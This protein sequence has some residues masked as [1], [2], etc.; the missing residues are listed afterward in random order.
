MADGYIKLHR[1]ILDS[2]I[3]ASA[4]GLKIWIWC[5][6]KAT[7]KTKHIPVKI[8]KGETIVTIQPGQFIFGR[9]TAEESLCI[10]GSTI[11]KWINKFKDENMIK[12]NSNSHYT[13]VTICK[14]DEY[15]QM[16]DNDVTAIQQPFN[17]HST[18]IQQPRNTNKNIKES[19]E[20]K[21]KEELIYIDEIYSAYP[22]K[23]P[24]RK[25]STS[26]SKKDKEKIKS[27]LSTI[28]KDKL[29]ATINTYVNDCK[30]NNIYLKN[31]KT[32]LNNIPDIDEEILKYDFFSM[33]PNENLSNNTLNNLENKFNEFDSLHDKKL[34][35]YNLPIN[36]ILDLPVNE[37]INYV[38][39][40]I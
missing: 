36:I 28:S 10:D 16:N 5:L 6:L 24:I 31:F 26:K 3:F 15:Q 23:C 32:F 40:R 21:E 39:T 34:K 19:K 13:I 8:G 20:S 33:F 4:Y 37:L 35:E 25:S 27:L 38:D 2:N 11:Y 22:A 12:L 17:S 9:F 29:L 14:W 30:K 18:A 1:S 7:Y